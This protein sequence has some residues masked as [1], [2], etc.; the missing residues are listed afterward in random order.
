MSG[1]H[2]ITSQ[3][4]LTTHRKMKLTNPEITEI[5]LTIEKTIEMPETIGTAEITGTVGRAETTAIIVTIEM[6]GI[7]RRSPVLLPITQ[8]H[9]C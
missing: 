1:T 3:E 4:T 6:M 5:N 8:E 9:R 2:G 7:T